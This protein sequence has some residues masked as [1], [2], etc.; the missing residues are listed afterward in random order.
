MISIAVGYFK[1]FS[2]YAFVST[3]SKIE[4]TYFST[5]YFIKIIVPAPLLINL[6]INERFK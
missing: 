1:L 4:Q 6:E 3:W 2:E 5:F